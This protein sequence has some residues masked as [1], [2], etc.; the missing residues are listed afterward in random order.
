MRY[1]KQVLLNVCTQ[2]TFVSKHQTIVVFPFDVLEIMEISHIGR[3]HVIAV[4]NSTYSTDCVEFIT[5]IMHILRC[6]VTP[7]GSLFR[8]FPSHGAT[9][10]SCVLAYLDR[11]GVD[12]EHI[13]SS[14]HCRCYVLADFLS[15]A[16]CE[17][18]TLIVLPTGDKMWQAVGTL[19]LQAIKQVVLAVDTEDFRSGGKSEDF[20]IRELGDNASARYIPEVINT[21]SGKFFEYVEDFSELYDE[22]VH[23]RDDS[24]QWFGHH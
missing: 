8:H 11:F 17:L 23:K 7:C 1:I 20:Q 6:T 2:I 19:I 16:V 14:I 15:E 18:A 3:C 12:A 22:V 21:I 9:C 13:L 24:N 4:D 5:I 10:S